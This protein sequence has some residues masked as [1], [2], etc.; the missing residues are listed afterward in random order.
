[1]DEKPHDTE[2]NLFVVAFF[3]NFDCPDFVTSHA[4]ALA[5]LLGK[6]ILLLHIIDSRY[7]Q[8]ETQNSA[9]QKLQAIAQEMGFSQEMLKILVL[10]GKT[11]EILETSEE[12]KEVICLVSHIDKNK[13]KNAA[14]P[15]VLFKHF[16][17]IRMAYLLV[18]KPFSDRTS[19]ENV[20]LTLD[21]E[22]ESKEKVIWASYF[23]RFNQS[24]IHLLHYKFKDD[25]LKKRLENNLLFVEKM[26]ENLTIQYKI[27]GFQPQSKNIDSLAISYAKENKAGLLIA[28]SDKKWNWF[29]KSRKMK[30]ATNEE[31]IPVLFLNPREDIYILCD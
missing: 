20:V 16:Q 18:Q 26:L 30:L 24:K 5:S 10:E 23:G 4:I 25:F 29:G 9:E 6:P 2:K 31:Q 28:L 22:K 13:P 19:L 15:S 1:M 14:H 3:P 17:N 8:I 12:L 21:I 7:K 11:D 27:T